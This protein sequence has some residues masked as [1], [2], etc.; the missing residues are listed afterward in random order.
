MFEGGR[1]GAGEEEEEEGWRTFDQLGVAAAEVD[2]MEVLDEV[3]LSGVGRVN[4][5]G[6]A[7]AGAAGGGVGLLTPRERLPLGF[8]DDLPVCVGVN[9]PIGV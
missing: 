4:D 5:G 8:V 1:E 9:P 6:G 7:S 2:L 3:A